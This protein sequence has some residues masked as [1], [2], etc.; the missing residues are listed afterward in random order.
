MAP[1]LR[2]LAGTSPETMVPITSLVNT[3]VSHTLSSPLF[4]GKIAA[5][6]KG[7]TDENGCVRESEYFNRE[8]KAGITWSIQVQGRFLVP[9]SADDILFGNTFDRPLKLP[10]GTSAILKFMH[11]IDPTLDHDLTSSTKPWALSPL[12]ATMPNF[13]HTRLEPHLVNA[14]EIDLPEFPPAHSIKDDIK[15]LHLAL[16]DLDD[17]GRPIGSGSRSSSN[18][19]LLSAQPTTALHRPPS[20]LSSHSAGSATSSA[21]HCSSASHSSSSSSSGSAASKISGASSLRIKQAMRKVHRR[22]RSSSREQPADGAVTSTRHIHAKE[23]RRLDPTSAS[24]RRAHFST[25]AHRSDVLLGQFDVVT[26][27]FC[28]GFINFAPALALQL[29]GGLSFD[30]MRYWDGQPVRFVCCKRPKH[31]ARS[32]EAPWGRIFWCVAIEMVDS[33]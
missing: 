11:Y 25:Q 29:P 10:W 7:V 30:L 5:Y 1:R 26:T 31:G 17:D 24:Q 14:A 27:D 20:A 12:I 15:Q 33:D 21:S 3:G 8:D 13:A 22:K 23:L 2:V 28:Y 16:V 6:I 32:G 19:S 4:E 9:Q 18:M